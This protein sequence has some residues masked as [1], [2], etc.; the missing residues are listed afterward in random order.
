MKRN[1]DIH[2]KL[3]LSFIVRIYRFPG[4]AQKDLVGVVEAV[5]V[6]GEKG[7][8]GIDELWAILKGGGSISGK[9]REKEKTYSRSRAPFE[10][11]LDCLYVQSAGGNRGEKSSD[12]FLP[13]VQL[14][15]K[16]R[17]DNYA[18]PNLLGA[19]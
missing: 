6:D 9:T 1:K 16:E 11:W 12:L 2:D 3:P 14:K 8:T 4:D 5:G 17:G 7:F 10:G 13:D 15:L 18:F 19:E